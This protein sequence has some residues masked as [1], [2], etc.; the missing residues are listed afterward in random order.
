MIEPKTSTDGTLSPS[1]TVVPSDDDDNT[2]TGDPHLDRPRDRHLDRP[3][4]L[5]STK[6]LRRR[7]NR[8]L[9][10]EVDLVSQ[11]Q[12]RG[13]ESCLGEHYKLAVQ[14][15]ESHLLV[16]AVPQ[17]GINCPMVVADSGYT[18]DSQELDYEEGVP[19]LSKHI[20]IMEP[21]HVTEDEIESMLFFGNVMSL[22]GFYDAV[23][24]ARTSASKK[25]SLH[26]IVGNCATFI[27]DV[28]TDL[29]IDFG[30]KDMQTE[31]INFVVQALMK[32]EE[33]DSIV[34]DIK[35]KINSHAVKAWVRL[36]G[37]NYVLK[38][39]VKTFLENYKID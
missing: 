24:I 8:Q 4:D 12:Q 1:P 32:S 25:S 28:M 22:E 23:Q 29:Q 31:L 27:L 5:L 10:S 11:M 36:R 3:R 30:K 34:A 15:L 14:A 13:D 2:E 37:D 33:R 16:V 7:H 19:V 21:N 6:C 18:L 39:F 20:T 17:E 35:G 38:K 9:L 26:G